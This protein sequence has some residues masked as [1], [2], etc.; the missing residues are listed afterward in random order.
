MRAVITDTGGGLVQIDMPLPRCPENGIRL[1]VAFVGICGSDLHYAASGKNGRYV[2]TGPMVLGHEL[3]GVV[4]EIGS[5]AHTDCVVGDRVAV[6][7]AWPCPAPGDVAP[8]RPYHLDSSGTYLG[9]AS[10]TPHTDGGLAEY[11]IVEADQLRKLP[12]HLPLS[13]AVLAEPLAVALHGVNR[14]GEA[15]ENAHALVIGAGPIGILTV[16]ALQLRG[17]AKVDI[18]DLHDS[19]LELAARIGAHDTYNVSQAE[20]PANESYDIVIEASGSTAGLTVALRSVRRGGTVVQLGILPSGKLPIE[21]SMIVAKEITF[22]G[23]QRFLGE[24]DEALELLTH[25]PDLAAVISHTIP[26]E[27]S[28]RAFELAADSSASSKVVISIKE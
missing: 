28:Q 2:V 25:H 4:D 9:S 23:S 5:Q 13:R 10:T 26:L 22:A 18:S 21:A 16:A 6:H 14:A 24:L 7:P 1:R 11:L 15:V 12:E 8:R 17:A 19:P 20:V 3:V 27:E